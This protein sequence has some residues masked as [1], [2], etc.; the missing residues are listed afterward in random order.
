[1]KSLVAIL[2]LVLAFLVCAPP[3]YSQCNG[4]RGGRAAR[5]SAAKSV[6]SAG[7][8]VVSRVGLKRILPRNR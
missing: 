6:R 2:C 8:R 7:I 5:V 4:S 3:A 1:M